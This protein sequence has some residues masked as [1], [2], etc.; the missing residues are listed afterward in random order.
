[1]RKWILLAD[2]W[3]RLSGAAMESD[4]DKFSRTG[5]RAVAREFPDRNLMKDDRM[6]TPTFVVEGGWLIHQFQNVGVKL[7]NGS[8]QGLQLATK[9][10]GH[11]L[12]TVL[13]IE[14]ESNAET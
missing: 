5:E 3:Q 4:F 6:K 9:H 1:M 13:V 2:S 12:T 8:P 11:L 10:I 7:L 14:G